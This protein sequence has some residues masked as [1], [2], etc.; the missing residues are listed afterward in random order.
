MTVSFL[1]ENRGRAILIRT[2]ISTV[3]LINMR[4]LNSVNTY[5]CF[6][7][8]QQ[9]TFIQNDS[10]F[11]ATAITTYDKP[12]HTGKNLHIYMYMSDSVVS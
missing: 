8:G 10:I 4:C 7:S 9:A 11:N 3:I 12:T 1:N 2:N 6:I 5:V